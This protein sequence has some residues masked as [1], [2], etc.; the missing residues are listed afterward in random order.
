MEGIGEKIKNKKNE[1]VVRR[2]EKKKGQQSILARLPF[3]KKNNRR[4]YNETTEFMCLQKET[5]IEEKL[6]KKRKNR[7][8]S[9]LISEKNAGM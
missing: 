4:K 3:P 7:T 1:N 5:K 2:K 6:Q 9:I 8:F